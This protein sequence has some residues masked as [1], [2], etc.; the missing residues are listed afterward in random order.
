PPRGGVPAFVP[1][2]LPPVPQGPPPSLQTLD[3][4]VPDE[5]LITVSSTAPQTLEADIAQAFNV[6]LV[7]RTPLPLIDVRLVRLRIP[8]SRTVPAV[9]AAIG[10]DPR[11]SLAQPNFLYRR[12]GEPARL[13]AAAVTSMTPGSS[14][15]Y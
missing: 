12:S 1:P 8:D 3:T 15:Q 4:F 9:V 14:I 13:Q 6:V 7:D 10:A 5:V 2:A 11:V